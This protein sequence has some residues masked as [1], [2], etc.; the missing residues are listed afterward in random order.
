MSCDAVCHVL[1]SRGSTLKRRALFMGSLANIPPANTDRRV[2]N[3]DHTDVHRQERS[4]VY[5]TYISLRCDRHRPTQH[6]YN[7]YKYTTFPVAAVS[8]NLIIFQKFNSI[9]PTRRALD[10][11]LPETV[12]S[13]GGFA[14][15]NALN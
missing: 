12:N 1:R 15:R 8:P 14:K 9:Q 6:C 11:L 5:K 3:C 2:V 13:D 7:C 4:V 10:M